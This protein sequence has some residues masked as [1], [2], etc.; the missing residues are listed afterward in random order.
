MDK[1]DHKTIIL[2]DGICNLCN[3]AVQF[4]LKRE[5]QEQFVFASLQS[6]AAKYILLQYNVKKISMDSILFIEDGQIYQKSTAVLKISKYLNWPW[7]MV[8]V[9]RLLP[10]R[11]RDKMY[12][13]IA[14]H[15]YSW[16]GRKDTCMMAIPEYK[17]RFI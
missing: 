4:L 10:L 16:F 5:K 17:N 9:F 11:F 14:K 8:S 13:L 15:R 6:D 12:D 7:T 2:F 1:K 3:G